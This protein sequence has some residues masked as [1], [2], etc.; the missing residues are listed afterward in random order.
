MTLFPFSCIFSASGGDTSSSAGINLYD[1]LPATESG[2]NKRKLEDCE[3]DEVPAKTSVLRKI[4]TTLFLIFR[5]N[6]GV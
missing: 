1:D 2:N 5:Y 6:L 4:M 3:D